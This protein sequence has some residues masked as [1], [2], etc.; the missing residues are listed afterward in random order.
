MRRRFPA[1]GRR[2]DGSAV[3]EFAMVV[4]MLMLLFLALVGVGVWAYA[5]TLLN[6]AAAQAAR[7][8]ASVNLDADAASARAAAIIADTV[9]GGVAATV[10]CDAPAPDPGDGARPAMIAV[11]CRMD[12]PRILPLIGGLFPEI[13]VTAHVLREVP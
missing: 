1:R 7:F 11:S 3:A 10:Q 9:V 12:A 5:H 4:V 13:A 2:D 8:A 6:S